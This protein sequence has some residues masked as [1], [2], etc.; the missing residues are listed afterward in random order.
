MRL[1]WAYRLLPVFIFVW[2]MNRKRPNGCVMYDE[3]GMW[4]YCQPYDDIIIKRLK[5]L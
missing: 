4:P 1:N 2:L 3:Q 5:K